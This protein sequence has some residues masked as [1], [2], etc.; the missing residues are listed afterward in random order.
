MKVR[1]WSFGDRNQTPE[2]H[3]SSQPAVHRLLFP[4]K[5]DWIQK[6]KKLRCD[7][8]VVL[9]EKM[10]QRKG[11][12]KNHDFPW[13]LE[14]DGKICRV[15]Q[16]RTVSRTAGESDNSRRLLWSGRQRNP[17]RREAIKRS[18]LQARKKQNLNEQNG[19]AS[20]T[21]A[22]QITLLKIFS[23]MIRRTLET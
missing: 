22:T 19:A 21:R 7:I 2:H 16:P 1:L 13:D 8:S 9:I 3:P 20:L 18:T 15:P 4:V 11:W 14:R 23:K 17:Y 5:P 6:G 10:C 12:L